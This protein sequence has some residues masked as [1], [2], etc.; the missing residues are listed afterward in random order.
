MGALEYV[1]MT[2]PPNSA[3]SA[4]GAAL[5]YLAFSG[6]DHGWGLVAIS[7]FTGYAATASTMLVN[8]YVDVEV[9]RV[10]KPWKPLPS[11]RAS[12]EIALAVAA[13]L[14]TASA[15][16]NALAAG[17]AP[18]VAV[19]VYLALGWAYCFLRRM[20]WN[21]VLVALSTTGPAVY[22]YVLAGL[23][24]PWLPFVAT[25][26]ATIFTTT[27]GREAVKALQD[28]EGDARLGYSSIPIRWGRSAALG[29]IAAAGVIGPVLGIASWFTAPAGPGYLL[30]MLIAGAIYS[31]AAFS[32]VRSGGR[33]LEAARRAMLGAMGIGIMA[34]ALL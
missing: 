2:R 21:H 9:D 28:V 25:Y 26:S 10:N 31:C 19:V 32:A 20:W 12:P 18:F 11:G 4:L 27:L 29:L 14:A 23:P 7:A 15:T 30:A 16:A 17:P 22:G 3:L 24:I 1:R 5:A 33:S 6:S 34:L 8:D 13:S